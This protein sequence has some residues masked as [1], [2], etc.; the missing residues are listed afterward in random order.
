M[1]YLY[2]SSPLEGGKPISSAEAKKCYSFYVSAL[3]NAAYLKGIVYLAR[4]IR[5]DPN[6]FPADR[7]V[8]MDYAQSLC[9]EISGLDLVD[10]L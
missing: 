8:L 6:L 2:R 9:A 5:S 7:E 10:V 3:R 4:Y 1:S